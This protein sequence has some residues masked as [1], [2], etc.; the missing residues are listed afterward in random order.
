MSHSL[1]PVYERLCESHA[2]HRSKSL[3]SRTGCAGGHCSRKHGRLLSR[4]PVRSDKLALKLGCVLF[5]LF[6]WFVYENNKFSN[7]HYT[8]F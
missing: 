6:W 2:P 8:F 5:Y 1:I 7:T 3:K 4:S